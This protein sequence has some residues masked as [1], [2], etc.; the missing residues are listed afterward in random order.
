M[1]R[2]SIVPHTV[3]NFAK[4]IH[5]IVIIASSFIVMQT[6]ADMQRMNGCCDHE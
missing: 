1:F 2:I 4:R 3:L 6:A 5:H